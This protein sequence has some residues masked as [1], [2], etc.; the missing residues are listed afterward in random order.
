[1]KIIK[2]QVQSKLA[3]DEEWLDDHMPFDSKQEA[4]NYIYTQPRTFEYRIIIDEYEE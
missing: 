2:Y 3:K 4:I 1:M